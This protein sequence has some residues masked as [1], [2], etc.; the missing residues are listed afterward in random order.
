MIRVLIVD[1]SPFVCN[2]LAG[3]LQRAPEI[4]VIGTALNGHRAIDLICE[5]RPDVVTLDQEMPELSGLDSL[6]QIMTE[7]PTPV[8]MISGVSR[9]A[10]GLTREALRIGAVDF[11]LKYTPGQD[12]SPDTLR[13]EIVSKVKAAAGIK[14]IRSISARSK[15]RRAPQ[16]V[17]LEDA[18][19]RANGL[20]LRGQAAH[21]LP[22]GIVVIGAST[23]GPVAVRELL[24]RLPTNFAPAVLIVQHIPASFTDVL[25][26]QLSRHTALPVKE[27]EHGEVVR[28]GHVYVAPGD[29]HML[30][31]SD[32]RIQLNNGPK[33]RG[34]RPAIDVTM[35]A[36][37][38]VYGAKTTGIVLTG[39]GDD[40]SE[41]LVAI[42]AKGGRTFAQDGA[43]SVV[44][45][46]PLR[47]RE[48]GVVD[49]VGSP[50]EIAGWLR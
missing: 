21:F 7:C 34:H 35:Q 15:T 4:E 12:V 18:T 19:V 41:G 5:L 25:A 17:V 36:V 3:H 22:A 1:D 27:A 43:S 39:M 9:R 10:A 33:I 11:V 8:V 16:P 2:L 42:R 13:L 45:G 24:E 20:A 29:S 47:A 28:G 26:A 38:Q 44:N 31:S 40:G 46:M 6:A 49:R 23:G 48:R 14:V 32:S 50:S 30:I 37:A